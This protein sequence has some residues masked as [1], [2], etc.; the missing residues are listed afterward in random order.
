MHAAFK[1]IGLD[2]LCWQ[3]F[4]EHESKEQN[5]S[6]IGAKYIQAQNMKDE[7]YLT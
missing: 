7:K 2:L 4:W 1:D 5:A 3:K 6:I